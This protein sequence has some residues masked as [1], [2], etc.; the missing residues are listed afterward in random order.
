MKKILALIPVLCLVIAMFAGT[1][2][3]ADYPELTLGYGTT[4]AEGS[5][6][7]NAMHLFADKVNAASE[8]KITIDLYPGSQLGGSNE[9]LEQVQLGTLAMC[10]SS[11]SQMTSQG[12][13]ELA[14]LGLPYL[15]KS[16][17]H[18]WNVLTGEVGQKY[19]DI[20][21]EECQGVVGF[22]FFPDGARHFFLNTEVKTLD[23]MKGLKIRVQDTSIDNAW[24]AALG[25]I[26]TPTATSE[27]Y[28]S[29]SNGLVDGAEQPLAGYYASK[30]YEVSKYLILDGY[31]YNILI[32]IFSEYV[33]NSLDAEVQQ[34][35]KDCWAEVLEENYTIITEGQNEY[36][37]KI[38]EAGVEVSTPEDIDAWSDAMAP[39]Y[40]EFGAGLE[41]LI[42]EIMAV[43][44]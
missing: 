4:A 20:I 19:L 40:E 36:I 31:T 38:K 25:A 32:P 16:Y 30:Y 11:P 26:A 37:E 24:C 6:S 35:L 8:G 29:M 3:M 33:W 2:A 18:Y 17:D 9:L 39:V 21:T 43:E 10:N 7:V 5:I 13:S 42:A 34:L 22:G 15:Y 44:G 27:I 23:D 41:D 14:A 12:V 1:A 28:S